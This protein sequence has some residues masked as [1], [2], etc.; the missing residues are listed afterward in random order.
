[1]ISPEKLPPIFRP[2]PYFPESANR[3]IV[4]S[5]ELSLLN[6]RL[7]NVRLLARALGHKNAY[8]D[9]R[10]HPY[11]YTREIEIPVVPQGTLRAGTE[12]VTDGKRRTFLYMNLFYEG[13]AMK[14]CS[15]YPRDGYVDFGFRFTIA[16]FDENALYHMSSKTM[17]DMNKSE[18]DMVTQMAD[19]VINS[20]RPPLR[21][22]DRPP[23]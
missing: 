2:N 18:Y 9:D 14:F 22:P 20:P 8:P 12:M 1:M 21:L 10:D 23:E 3:R 15:F 5:E 13:G 6:D 4:T 17:K 11:E 16:D 19:C 7:S